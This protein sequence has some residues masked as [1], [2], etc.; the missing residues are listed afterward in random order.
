MSAKRKGG[1]KSPTKRKAGAPARPAK[2]SA[3]AASKASKVDPEDP[4]GLRVTFGERLADADLP[5]C[6]I[7]ILNLN[8]RH[9]L[10]PCFETLAALDYPKDKFEVILVEN[11]STDGSADE[12]RRDH[13]WVKL[14]VNERNVGFAA[15]CNQGVEL[16][17]DPDVVV[18]LNNDMRVEPAWLRTLVEPVAR[19]EHAA[20]TSKML[21]W[22]GKLMNSAG[23]G[24]NFHGIGIQRG[25][26][27][28]I[29]EAYAW[30]RLTLFACGGAMAMDAKV[31]RELG[32]FD[33]EYFAYYEDVD[34]G[35]RTWIAGHSIA[36][37]PESIA[38]HH[39]SSTSGR[40]PI[41]M[42]RLLQVRNP[43]YTC[44]KNYDDAN[45]RR[46]LPAILG[47]ATRRMLLV[48][49][50]EDDTPFRIEKANPAAMGS[51]RRFFE[52]ARAG[53]GGDTIPIK[54]VAIAD[55][56][57]MNDLLGRWEHWMAKR[58]AVQATRRTPDEDILR[59]FL[60]PHWCIEGE[61]GYKDL[62]E[63]MTAFF[64]LD[65]LF[66][67]CTDLGDEPHK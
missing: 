60:R 66:E 35:W 18:F 59:L 4:L 49:G 17:D 42:I 30:P 11:G 63:G 20:T 47:L 19:G 25:Y 64:G 14:H 56:I 37:C 10:K 45:L 40:L 7:V 13:Q 48:G 23:G 3:P 12:M 44:V 33:D 16:A 27:D 31:Y 65:E 32:G 46:A 57:G 9:H 54:R 2:S 26:L 28:E 38:Y 8:G 51:V 43:L 61:Q 39:H 58:D 67:G 1:A 36:Y 15:G 62:H 34:L 22:D 41:E 6:A 52:R 53:K 24:M 55:L 50:I 21:S 29:T 5:R